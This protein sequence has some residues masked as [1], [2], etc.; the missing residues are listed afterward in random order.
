MSNSPIPTETPSPIAA[1]ILLER[2]ENVREA[3]R[4]LD[5]AQAN[6]D[7]LLATPGQLLDGSTSFALVQAKQRYDDALWALDQHRK[8]AA[9]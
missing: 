6:Y 3:A 5:A 1:A 8:A 9:G 7:R 4:A 2:Q